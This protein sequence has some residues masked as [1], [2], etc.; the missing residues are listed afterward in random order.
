MDILNFI[1]NWISS[2]R[3]IFI[4]ILNKSLIIS[5]V[6]VIVIFIR[7]LLK[8]SPKIFSYLLW[9]VVA[10]RLAVP[11]SLKSMFSLIP[12]RITTSTIPRETI[13]QQA[14]EVSIE[15]EDVENLVTNVNNTINTS[16]PTNN[17]TSVNPMEIYQSIG[18]LVWIIG[19][20]ALLSYSII[21]IIK[22]KK[23]LSNATFIE[24][25]IYEVTNLQT[26]FV[27]GFLKP[28]IYLPSNLTEEERR[29]IIK[30]EEIHIKRKDYIVKIF[31]F[32]LLMIYWFNPFVWVAFILMNK[33]MEYSCDERV[34]KEL[35][36]D[37]KK[38]YATSLV[39]LATDKRIFNGSPLAFGEG[40]VKGR[41]K[42]VLSYKKPKFWIM[43]VSIIIL[44]IVLGGLFA[45]PISNEVE[46][47]VGL[48]EEQ[49]N[50]FNQA[51]EESKKSYTEV[52][53]TAGD[54]N[55]S[56][57][58]PLIFFLTSY[59][60]KPENMDMSR[61]LHYIPRETYL[62]NEDQEEYNKLVEKFG[63]P[64][65]NVEDFHSPT[66][67]I[68][69]AV[70]E[71]YLNEYMNLSISD[72]ANMGD[73]L[74]LDE[75]DTFYSQASDMWSTD[76]ICT[77]GT[78]EGNII[79]L[80]SNFE[81]L[82]IEKQG[83]KYYIKSFLPIEGSGIN[84][85]NK[86]NRILELSKIWAE[87]YSNKDGKA[88]YD[89]MTPKYQQLYYSQLVE[90]NGEE[91]PW[92]IRGS[93]P[94]V[95]SYDIV[96][97]GDS[98]FITYKMVDSGQQEYIYQEQVFFT[99]ENGEL[100]VNNYIVQVDTMWP[101]VYEQA[102]EIQKQVDNGEFEWRLKPEDVVYR[103]VYYDLGYESGKV[104]QRANNQ[105]TFKTDSGEEIEVNLYRPI[106]QDET[107]FIAVHDYTYYDKT[108]NEKSLNL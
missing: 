51:L 8:K 76:F 75:Y 38:S 28:L 21:S 67:R 20:I 72:M 101:D 71:S 95:D 97:R 84:T 92:Y 104:T 107:G 9:S 81:T 94:W 62:T 13:L 6:I 100:L 18:M 80:S 52:L 90:I 82:T 85:N 41:V 86:D 66:G 30:H 24:K 103:F 29:Y 5:Y 93:S 34:I 31:A 83:D 10:F 99:E 48:T 26:P 40:N 87:A 102:V 43:I 108:K 32:I 96:Q 46:G 56:T 63:I 14:P 44:I 50:T 17:I 106:R 58:K 12:R 54:R 42:N 35:D 91:N 19:I 39:S 79:T 22:L 23:Q 53:Q 89:I 61:F 69:K 60:D 36:G 47:A 3:Y 25:N 105:Y 59:Y 37:I 45:N 64:S 2:N 68:P 78:I 1:L 15:V 55:I 77:S 7:F 70:I 57:V 88:R 74:Y 33:D 98:V 11:F 16:T 4:D 27:F 73:T 49:I 65:G